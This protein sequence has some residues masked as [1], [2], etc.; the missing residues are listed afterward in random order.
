MQR[1]VIATIAHG[2]N[3]SREET[4]GEVK[5]PV[6]VDASKDD[7]D[8]YHGEILAHKNQRT[9][10]PKEVFDML[11]KNN[12][13]KLDAEEF[14]DLFASFPDMISE[15]QIA[16][17]FAFQDVD[18]DGSIKLHEFEEGW[19]FM[20][21]TIVELTVKASGL[22]TTDIVGHVVTAVIG[23]LSLFAFVVL[24]MQSWHSNSDLD[25][26]V[27]TFLIF[28]SGKLVMAFRK[29]VPKEKQDA[30]ATEETPQE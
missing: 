28:S 27:Q 21:Q 24:A 9:I 29:R 14:A 26:L 13:K 4:N 2:V 15:A 6:K 12:D 22:S 1:D 5:R 20:L 8:T 11:D 25:S 17:M 18:G 3:G 16:R 10:T 7:F 30:E 23:L 19:A